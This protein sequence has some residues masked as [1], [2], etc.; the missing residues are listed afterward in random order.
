MREYLFALQITCWC[1]NF[2]GEKSI[3]NSYWY[4]SH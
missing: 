2:W 1:T 3:H 4:Q